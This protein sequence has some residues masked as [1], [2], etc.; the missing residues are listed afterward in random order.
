V[1]EASISRKTN[2]TD[3]VLKLNLDG[4]GKCDAASGIG[5]FDH[6]LNSFARHGQ[7]DIELRCRGDLHV[8]THH[9]VEDIGIVLG[10]AI[11]EAVGDK[12]GIRRY[13]SSLLPMDESLVMTVIDLSGRPFFVWDAELK[14]ERVGTLET[15]TVK[16]FFAA[17]AYSAAMNLHIKEMY[18]EN[19]HHVIEAMFKAFA[20]ALSEAVSSD[21]K[22]T[23][24]LSTKGSL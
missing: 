2:E 4:S 6:M 21:P 12:K 15:G 23:G 1:R 8:D 14:A 7:F 16:E 3:I 9:T 10:K 22:I 18:G 13:G 19:T 17:I 20:R 5:F 11:A 24:I